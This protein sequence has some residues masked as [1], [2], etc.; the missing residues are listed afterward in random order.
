MIPWA[1][2][3]DIG[4]IT[5]NENL[6]CGIAFLLGF[7][8]IGLCFLAAKTKQVRNLDLLTQHQELRSELKDVLLF[9]GPVGLISFLLGYAF[10]LLVVAAI[11]GGFVLITLKIAMPG[12][13]LAITKPTIEPAKPEMTVEPPPPSVETADTSV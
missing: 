3:I 5:P 4:E 9:L 2:G 13:R 11:L 7:A 6:F 8:M 12:I 10:L 1:L